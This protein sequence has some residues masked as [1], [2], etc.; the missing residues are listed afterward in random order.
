MSLISLIG[1]KDCL[2]ND[3]YRSVFYRQNIRKHIKK[4][5]RTYTAIR[6]IRCAIM[7]ETGKEKGGLLNRPSVKALVA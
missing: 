2:A 6:D 3:Q 1:S 7:Q 4:N 5:I